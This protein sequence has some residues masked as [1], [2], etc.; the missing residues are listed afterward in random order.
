LEDISKVQ[1][2]LNYSL[3]LTKSG[4]VYAWGNN[5]YGQLGTGSLKN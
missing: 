5:V 1:S 2:G 4:K 3:A